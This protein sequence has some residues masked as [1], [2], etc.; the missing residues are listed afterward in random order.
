MI[1][2]VCVPMRGAA[3]V[4]ISVRTFVDK[5]T[6]FFISAVDR[7]AVQ[8]VVFARDPLVVDRFTIHN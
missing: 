3:F 5:D 2:A 7:F 8:G 4:P 1:V 6:N